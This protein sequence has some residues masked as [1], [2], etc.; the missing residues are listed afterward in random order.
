MNQTTTRYHLAATLEPTNAPRTSFL[1][2]LSIREIIWSCVPTLLLPSVRWSH[3]RNAVP[4]EL[5]RAGMTLTHWQQ[6]F[7]ILNDGF[8]KERQVLRC[9]SEA[10]FCRIFFP[11]TCMLLVPHLSFIMGAPMVAG[12]PKGMQFTLMLIWFWAVVFLPQRLTGYVSALWH[13]SNCRHQD[14]MNQLVDDC[15]HQL[16]ALDAKY[17]EYAFDM[18]RSSFFYHSDD[19]FKFNYIFRMH[20][21][22]EENVDRSNQSV[23]QSPRN[24]IGETLGGI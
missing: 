6:E 13:E 5:A 12:A 16:E 21:G 2:R 18:F 3:S 10:R 4:E 11:W 23:L 24:E 7:D 20:P 1:R 22:D 17:Q 15:H 14:A 8:W 9:R 19:I